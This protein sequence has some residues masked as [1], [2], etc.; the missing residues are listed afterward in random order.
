MTTNYNWLDETPIAY[1][2]AHFLLMEFGVY[3]VDQLLTL[4]AENVKLIKGIGPKRFEQIVN[5]LSSLGY[6]LPE[7]E[8][9]GIFLPGLQE[10]LEYLANK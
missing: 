6:E 10:H 2:A 9:P 5:M 1:T 7:K 3:T 8:L 4:S